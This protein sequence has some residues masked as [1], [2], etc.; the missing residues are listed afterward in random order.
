MA[1]KDDLPEPER[2][3]MLAKSP[4]LTAMSMPLTASISPPAQSAVSDDATVV[5]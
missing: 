5:S 1:R 2:P 3:T 4:A